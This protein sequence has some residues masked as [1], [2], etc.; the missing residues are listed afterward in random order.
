MSACLVLDSYSVFLHNEPF[1]ILF[2]DFNSPASF[3]FFFFLFLL[4]GGH[5]DRSCHSYCLHSFTVVL[6]NYVVLPKR[7]RTVC[8]HSEKKNATLQLFFSFSFVRFLLRFTEIVII[9][10]LLSVSQIT[11]VTYNR[12]YS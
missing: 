11:D 2:Y 3:F 6:K 1:V 12:I 4:K 9:R 7:K 8:C 5:G 10:V